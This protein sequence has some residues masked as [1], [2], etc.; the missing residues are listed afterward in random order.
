MRYLLLVLIFCSNQLWSQITAPVQKIDGVDYYMHK[1]ESGQTLYSISK[2]YNVGIKE[3]QKT[4]NLSAEG[5]QLGQTLKIR[6]GGSGMPNPSDQLVVPDRANANL[7]VASGYHLVQPGETAYSISQKYKLKVDEFYGLNPGTE[8]G[9]SINQK[10]RISSKAPA[11]QAFQVAPKTSEGKFKVYLLLPFLSGVPDSTITQRQ[12]VIRQTALELYRGMLLT[13][14]EMEKSGMKVEIE[15]VDFYDNVELI[16]QWTQGNRLNDADLIIGPL[17]KE[18]LEALAPWAKKRNIWVVCPVPIS[19]KILMGN[20]RVIKAFPSDVSQWGATAR[21]VLEKKSNAVPVFLYAGKT[22]AEKKRSEAFRVRYLKSGAKNLKV[23]NNL[24]SL[25]TAR[26]SQMDSMVVVIPSQSPEIAR[27]FN[28]KSHLLQ[29]TWVLGMS[30][31]VD[32][33]SEGDAEGETKNKLKF[34]FTKSA[35]TESE[36][37]DVAQWIKQ[38]HKAYF[39]HPTE[40]SFCGHDILKSFVQQQAMGKM[41]LLSNDMLSNGLFCNID[42]VQVGRGNGFENVGVVI[43]ESHQGVVIRVK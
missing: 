22:E 17:F 1:V 39:T 4:N 40:Y 15:V 24:D 5:V 35:Q 25:L 11:Q 34:T 32:H 33:L 20:E 13:E 6:K 23:S 16:K 9:L 30:E 7:N 3:I 27:K 12:K 10:V 41:D 18:S 36:D 31:W 37:P 21:Y 38:Y 42:L 8:N 29:R 2:L 43:M 28:G 14:E 26:A 19:N